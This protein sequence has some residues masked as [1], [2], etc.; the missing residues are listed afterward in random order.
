MSICTSPVQPNH[1][2]WFYSRLSGSYHEI[3]LQHGLDHARIIS[4]ILGRMRGYIFWATGFEWNF[5]RRKVW[6]L[7]W[8]RTPAVYQEEMLGI[9]S[10]ATWAGAQPVA[11]EDI[12]LWNAWMEVLYYY[13]PTYQKELQG[14]GT[15]AGRSVGFDSCS[16]FIATGS[17]T[18]DGSIVM[19]H[20]SFM[21]YELA[22]HRL[23]LDI[24]TPNGCRFVMQT[25]PGLI[26]SGT[27]FGV[28]AKGLMVT[29]TTMGGFNN[30][31]DDSKTLSSLV[32]EFVRARMSLE[33]SGSMDDF[34]NILRE[35]NT[36]GHANSWLVGD[37]CT[38]TIMRYELGYRYEA[39]TETDDGQFI[40]YSTAID[41][42]IRNLECSDTGYMD[43]RRRPGSDQVR[44]SILLDEN[45]G[46]VTTDLGRRILADYRDPCLGRSRSGA[47]EGGA[48]DAPDARDSTPRT[49]RHPP[50]QPH[51]AIDGKVM[52]S[53]MA[54]ELAFTAR[55][56]SPCGT[57]FDAPDYF[58]RHPQFIDLEPYIESRSSQAWT[59]TGEIARHASA[60]RN[61][62]PEALGN[63]V[64]GPPRV[65]TMQIT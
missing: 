28:N 54:R 35:G 6:D 65:P 17:V 59:D 22:F 31:C 34:V 4:R 46:K 30:Y 53:S 7:W 32:P 2:G 40:G 61:Q 52:D 45:R 51:G 33:Q 36:G 62:D 12:F 26:S 44:L 56:G 39:R 9:A 60:R 58:R 27:D 48:H 24:S 49:D 55:W 21:P 16:A 50:F 23:I 47:A 37:A 18:K 14:I 43:I 3:G 25:A 64:H 63:A 19:A 42:R 29:E 1:E 10:G 13:C 38:G 41:P 11:V 5:I 20:S 57:A 8:N 15:A